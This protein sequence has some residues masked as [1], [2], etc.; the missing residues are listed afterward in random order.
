MRRIAKPIK[1]NNRNKILMGLD[2]RDMLFL[3]CLFAVLS[4]IWLPFIINKD[5]WVGL[6]LAILDC[7]ISGAMVMKLGDFRVYSWLFNLVRFGWTRVK[8]GELNYVEK[9]E[10]NTIYLKDKTNSIYEFY[11]I[12]GKDVSLLNEMDFEILADNLGY[13]FK[14]YSSLNL[15]KIDG[16]INLNKVSTYVYSLTSDNEKLNHEII[17]NIEK[18]KELRENYNSSRQSKYF[19]SF[20][21]EEGL[22]ISETVEKMRS[23]LK[24]AELDII[25]A[26]NEEMV[27]I[28]EKLYFNNISVEE[29]SKWLKVKYNEVINLT[30]EEKQAQIQIEEKEE[31]ISFRNEEYY[32]NKQT[33]LYYVLKDNKEWVVCDNPFDIKPYGKYM[34]FIGL[35]AFPAV[36]G[37]SWLYSIFNMKGVDVNFK[38]TTADEKHLDREITKVLVNCEEKYNNLVNNNAIKA[39][40]VEEELLGYEELA[41]AIADGEEIK[42]INCMIKLSGDS[43]KEIT[44]AVKTF[45]KLLRRQKFEFTRLQFNQFDAL[46]EFFATEVQGLKVNPIECVD[47]VLGY[48]FPF[49]QQEL[50]DNKGLYFGNDENGTPAF[51]DWK[52]IDSSKNSSSMILLGKTGSGKSTTTKRIIKNQILANEYKIFIID[53]ENE[54]GDLVEGLGGQRILINDPTQV[55]NPFDLNLPA[56]ATD[57]DIDNAIFDKMQFINTFYNIIFD[58][59][60]MA[61]K[62]EWL[63]QKT[64]ELYLLPKN[65]RKQLTFSDFFTYINKFN[66]VETKA[67]IEQFGYYCKVAGGN[68]AHIWDSYTTIDTSNNYIVFEFRDL[69]AKAG[70]S[71]VGT[72]QIFLVLQYLNNLVLNNRVDNAR[73][74]NIIVDE[75][76]LL[77]NPRY[78][79]VVEFLTEMYKRIRK[80]NGMMTLISQNVSDFYKPEIR[81]YSANMINNAFYIIS[82]TIKPQEVPMLNELMAEQGGLKEAEKEFLTQ[83][84]TGRCLLIYNKAR[85]KIEVQS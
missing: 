78:L 38:I 15:L 5:I 44:Q 69:L 74:I 43:P 49:V 26:T 16:K 60:V 65:K 19:V 30:E 28:A 2:W 8:H 27:D 67:A 13:F 41:N 24:N 14:D 6:G 39:R 55:I 64:N 70:A 84:H 45:T 82:H 85:T 22:D 57:E 1:N 72:A 32:K 35:K 3:F 61:D 76:H 68:K 33:G 17:D 79:Q 50:I 31:V 25:K 58:K 7:L 42:S 80:Y 48:G 54:Y 75:A 11:R 37:P 63:V 4:A 77:I 52:R 71:S 34:T 29:S 51:I 66:N 59:K 12:K 81:S 73:Y 18:L 21:K 83:D 10:G 36:V 53:P 20:K 23:A 62:I 40:L 9:V 46:K 47:N 56:D